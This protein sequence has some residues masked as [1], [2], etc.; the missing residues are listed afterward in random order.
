MIQQQQGDIWIQEIESLPTG[1]TLKNNEERLVLAKGE[2]HHKHQL[3]IDNDNDAEVYEMGGSTF[4]DVK[5][6]CTLAH[7]EHA[8]QLIK[9]GIYK[10]GHISE[11]DYHAE[12]TKKVLD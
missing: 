9:T 12:E 1:T 3:V 2:T 10:V 6:D 5:N 11:Y 4:L 8:A 7:E